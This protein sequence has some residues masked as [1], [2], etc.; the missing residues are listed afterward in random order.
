MSELALWLEQHI[1]ALIEAAMAELSSD[2]RL[3]ASV[4]ESIAAFYAALAHSAHTQ[5]MIPV[6]AILIDWIEARSAPTEEEPTGL[7]PVLTTLKRVAWKQ[8]CFFASPEEAVRLLLESEE[9]FT[10]AATYLATLEAEALLND[11]RRELYKA[12]TYIERLDKSKSDFIAV[13]AHELK[14]PLTL[15]EGYTNML[16]SEF[17]QE[18][19]ER[20]G[21]MLTGILNGAGRLR[22]IVEDMIDVSLIDLRLLELHFQPVW[23]D[24]LIAMVEL[25]MSAALQQRNIQ[26]EVSREELQHKFTYGDPERLYQVFYKVISNAV[27][28]TP[29]G[30]A[31][32]V[33]TRDLTGFTDVQVSDTGIGIAPENLSRIFERFA[34]MG[35]IALHSSGKVKFKGGGPGLGLAIAKGIIEAHGGSIWAES[36]GYD[37]RRLPG[38]TFHIMVPMRTSPPESDL[39]SA[40]KPQPEFNGVDE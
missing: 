1:T 6:H 35:D 31:I 29:D 24:R 25:D 39:T 2:E 27:K 23:L 20:V 36:P 19:Q 33:S 5:S 11:V 8:I 10:D 14:T 22:E 3:R 12:Q 18:E 21:L 40:V 13:A 4:E 17:T 26:L 15:I 16:H 30:G 34:T 38:S 7:L 37:E 9:L 28:F 32:S